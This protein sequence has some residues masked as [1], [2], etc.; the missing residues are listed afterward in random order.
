M[1]IPVLIAVSLAANRKQPKQRGFTDRISNLCVD[2][3]R[4]HVN[5]DLVAIH[6]S[7]GDWRP[8]LTI[9]R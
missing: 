5:S 8:V 7:V 1:I 6:A 9:Y 2:L 4:D 3:D